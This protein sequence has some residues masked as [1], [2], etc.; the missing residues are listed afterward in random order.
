MTQ[1]E[2]RLAAVDAATNRI[3][4]TAAELMVEHD[5]LSVLD[6]VVIATALERHIHGV[7][8]WQPAPRGLVPS[9]RPNVAFDGRALK[10]DTFDKRS[11]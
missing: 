6:C 5:D 3:F 2:R 8:D 11:T 4:A 9:Q 1:E 7:P 10:I